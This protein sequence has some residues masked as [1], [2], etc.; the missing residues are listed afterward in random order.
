L[1]TLEL[2]AYFAL[3]AGGA[4][5]GA[6]LQQKGK[7]LATREDLAE[8][9][10]KTEAIKQE[11]A[12]EAWLHQTRWRFKYDLYASL[13]EALQE[14]RQSLLEGERL[15]LRLSLSDEEFETFNATIQSD[16]AA[17]QAQLR[18]A[19]SRAALILPRPA[20]KALEQLGVE[21]RRS[22][23]DKDDYSEWLS[24]LDRTFHALVE[25]AKQDL[26]L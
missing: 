11:I 23:N 25:S 20:M 12:G 5:F 7:N 26:R 18:R 14:I 1:T 2:F 19:S 17:A 13:L 15:T 3:A 8:V 24:E 22:G 9:V 10:R 4:Y 6:Y 21:D 16:L